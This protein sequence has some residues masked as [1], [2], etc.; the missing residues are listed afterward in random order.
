MSKSDVVNYNVI[1][2]SSKK[3]GKSLGWAGIG[4]KLYLGFFKNSRIITTSGDGKSA[5]RCEM[6]FQGKQLK[7]DFFPTNKKIAGTS[8][9]VL[10]K[11]TDYE[12]LLKTA[13][14]LITKFKKVI[15][16]KSELMKVISLELE[17]IKDIDNTQKIFNH[18]SKMNGLSTSAKWSM[19]LEKQITA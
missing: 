3:F 17:N 16:S 13:A 1:A 10:L 15:N 5:L 11:K 18:R 14:E 6:W 8:Y 9:K 12:I 19:D 2:R 4:S 7:W